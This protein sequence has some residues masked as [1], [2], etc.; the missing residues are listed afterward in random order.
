MKDEPNS[1]SPA[2]F[3]LSQGMVI[4][5]AFASSGLGVTMWL[6]CTLW[7]IK[8]IA[9]WGDFLGKLL[10]PNKKSCWDEKSCSFLLAL[11]KVKGRHNAWSCIER[12]LIMMVKSCDSYRLN[13][14]SLEMKRILMYLHHRN[15][16]KEHG[17]CSSSKFFFPWGVSGWFMNPRCSVRKQAS[18]SPWV[19]LFHCRAGNS[20][21][22]LQTCAYFVHWAFHWKDKLIKSCYTEL[23]Q[24]TFAI[25][26]HCT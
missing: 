2:I 14:W 1:H 7:V 15:I 24:D 19:C 3:G 22:A 17:A 21:K 13:V 25:E 9:E 10:L 11:N 4:L 6:S 26:K 20:Q 18:N 5:L 8:R 16:K 12:P 23:D